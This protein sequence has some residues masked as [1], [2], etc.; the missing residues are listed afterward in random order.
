MIKP[1]VHINGT[2]KNEL[3][4]Q[5]LRAMTACEDAERALIDAAPHG[6]DYYPLGP[7]AFEF[8]RHEHEQRLHA[9]ADI[10]AAYVELVE[11]VADAG[12]GAT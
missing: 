12:R 7:G 3:M 9:L 5:F 6:R 1:R 2:G 10:R 8:A 4:A 11:H